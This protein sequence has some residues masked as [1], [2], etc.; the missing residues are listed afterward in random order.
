MHPVPS[1]RLAICFLLLA[2][3][4]PAAGFAAWPHDPASGVPVAP[5]LAFQSFDP[6]GTISD[7]LGGV[8]VAFTQNASTE[9]MLQRI[10]PDGAP[11]PG[12]PPGGVSLRA[13]P[14]LAYGPLVVADGAGGAIVVWNEQRTGRTEP[15]A[16]RVNAS[17][18][19]LWTPGGIPI[20]PPGAIEESANSVCSDGA[21]G[22]FVAY[23][24]FLSVAD[25]DI[26][27]S[28]V[29]SGGSV[30]ITPVA[31]PIARQTSPQVVEDG[32]GG[33]Y[34]A[35]EDDLSGNKELLLSHYNSLGSATWAGMNLDG[36]AANDQWYP[37]VIA[38]GA[39]GVIVSWLDDRAG[40]NAHDLYASRVDLNGS[41][42]AGAW[43]STGT[44][45][46][47]A[48]GTQSSPSMVPDGSGGLLA[49]WND[50]RPS[51]MGAYGIHLNG[52]GVRVPGWGADGTAI[53][54]F[55][56]NPFPYGVADGYGGALLVTQ[57]LRL[58]GFFTAWGERRTSAGGYAPLS[59]YG[60]RPIVLNPLGSVQNVTDLA[61]GAFVVWNDAHSGVMQV[62][63]NHLDRY[64]T[65]GESAPVIT[66]LFDVASDQGGKVRLQWDASWMDGDPDWGIG[67]YWIWRQTPAAA[68]Q[69]AVTAGGGTWTDELAPAE[70][71]SAVAAFEAGAPTRLFRHAASAT[72]YA[73]EFLASPPANGSAEYSYV[74][75]TTS[76]S[77]WT[78]FMVEAHS[79]ITVQAFWQS[80]AESSYSV[81]NLAPAMPAP[82]TGQYAAGTAW[83]HWNPNTESDLAGYRLYRGTSLGF[84]PG[85]GNLV[86]AQ[87]DTGHVDAAGSAFVYKL[88]AI[89]VHGNESL[90]AVLDPSGTV[91]VDGPRPLVLAFAL[92]SPNPS[93]AGAV[94]RVALPAAAR[95]RVAIYDAAGREVRRLADGP[96][97]PGEFTERWDG[98]DAAGRA[99]ASGL[100][101]ARLQADGRELV[102]RVAIAH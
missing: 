29:T 89:D 39:G 45:L 82:F 87:P 30:T 9:V 84:V 54:T 70:A 44:V 93:R 32:A 2:S 1:S 3:L 28:H 42:H 4:A 7:G 15:F 17:G 13:L 102:R 18:T 8:F 36:S 16:Q 80:E 59:L 34:V 20:T 77:A 66:Q 90:A 97:D 6:R 53:N 12:W 55:G 58:G 10:G 81:D 49:F 100:Y 78:A 40:L 38:D 65:L 86:S 51:G 95:V 52:S 61:G 72:D 21:G 35:Y 98:A 60:G 68:A 37:T 85:P 5:S 94:L 74:A 47:T 56:G 83:L 27:L 43:S 19:P 48:A 50:G 99:V 71:A 91:S 88:T 69:A 25:Y 11:A 63:V 23:A 64:A 92:A 33:C 73:W 62:Y 67:A 76:D 57:D 96:F 79:A 46:C 31:V 24:Y 14:S 101:F 26:Y 22:A 41:V 75:G